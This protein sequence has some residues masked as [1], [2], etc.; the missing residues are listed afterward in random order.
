[1][2][3]DGRRGGTQTGLMVTTPLLLP[4]VKCHQYTSKSMYDPKI[5][6]IVITISRLQHVG[7]ATLVKINTR[8]L[9]EQYL[10][11]LNQASTHSVV[12]VAA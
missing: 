5:Y 12:L 6:S 7:S 2:F 9:D 8:F 10:N 4:Y 3:L 1:M 11:L